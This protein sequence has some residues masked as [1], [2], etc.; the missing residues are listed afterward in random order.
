MTQWM[1]KNFHKSKAVIINVATKDNR[2][3][4]YWGIP[5]GQMV[6]TPIGTFT[7]DEKT[8][9]L[10]KKRIANY[11]YN[12]QNLFPFN[13]NT[14]ELSPMTPEEFTVFKEAEMAR[15]LY[16]ASG[17]RMNIMMVL[18]IINFV[19]LIGMGITYYLLNEKVV[20]TLE[21]L[22]LIGGVS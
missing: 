10:N 3:Y 20:Q 16:E 8:F 19:I 13:L 7:I 17:S 4:S 1:I 6:K 2:V 15:Q 18:L 9:L 14:K 5:K 12:S 11:Y 22:K 21:I